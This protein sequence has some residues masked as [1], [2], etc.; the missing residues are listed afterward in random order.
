MGRELT[1]K[2][3]PACR[4]AAFRLQRQGVPQS[5]LASKP[6]LSAVFDP[7]IT[8]DLGLRRDAAMIKEVDLQTQSRSKAMC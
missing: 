8:I 5:R 6:E 4:P 2:I 3:A 1:M 7:C